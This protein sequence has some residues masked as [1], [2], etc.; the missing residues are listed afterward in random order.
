MGALVKGAAR[1]TMPAGSTPPRGS[2][3]PDPA[4][5]ATLASLRPRYAESGAGAAS[6]ANLRWIAIP[7]NIEPTK[8]NTPT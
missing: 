3:S 2:V 8:T 1:E 5:P 7:T 4:S 6:R